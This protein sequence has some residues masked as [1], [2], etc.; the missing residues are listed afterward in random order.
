MRRHDRD[1]QEIVVVG[2]EIVASV[3]IATVAEKSIE[4]IHW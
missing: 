1:W 3:V 4:G 2:I